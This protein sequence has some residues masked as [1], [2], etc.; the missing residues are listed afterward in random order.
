M[1]LQHDVQRQNAL[2]TADI[3]IAALRFRDADRRVTWLS[4]ALRSKGQADT[5]GLLVAFRTEPDQSG[6]DWVK[7]TWLT[8]ERR[9]WE[10][11]AVVPREDGDAVAIDRFEDAT[12]RILVSAHVPGTGKSFGYLA[13]EVLDQ[14]RT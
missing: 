10:F 14:R 7:G 5:C 12:D 3:L 8:T 11:E 9:F 2:T 1:T 13:L 6:G 4:A